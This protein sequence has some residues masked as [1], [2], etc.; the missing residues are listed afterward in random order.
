MLYFY[1]LVRPFQFFHLDPK[2]KVKQAPV[3]ALSTDI[4]APPFMTLTLYYVQPLS[5]YNANYNECDNNALAR[6]KADFFE[7]L[8]EPKYQI[9]LLIQAHIPKQP[10][11]ITH[12]KGP[13]KP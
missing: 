6:I 11:T 5:E 13:I 8:R 2:H 4:F 7:Q 10:S 1:Y 12:Q 3:L 9:S